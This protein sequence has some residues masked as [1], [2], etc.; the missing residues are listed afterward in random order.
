MKIVNTKVDDLSKLHLCIE[1]IKSLEKQNV[2]YIDNPINLFSVPKLDNYLFFKISVKKDEDIIWN[3]FINQDIEQDLLKDFYVNLNGLDRVYIIETNEQLLQHIEKLESSSLIALDTE[4]YPVLQNLDGVKK[5]IAKLSLIQ[6]CI[7][8][9]KESN[10]KEMFV[11]NCISDINIEFL[12]TA[13]TSSKILKMIHNASYDV[14]RIRENKAI[15]LENVWCTQIAEEFAL[16][17]AKDVRFRLA[18]LAKR[19]LGVIMDK[20]LQHSEWHQRP[21]SEEQLVYSIR[22]AKHLYDI[23]LKQI[24]KGYSRGLYTVK[25]T[26]KA[27]VTEDDINNTSL[28]DLFMHND[29]KKYITWLKEFFVSG[30][31]RNFSP[32]SFVINDVYF[33][34]NVY[35]FTQ[36]LLLL[37][38]QTVDL[39]NTQ[40]QTGFSLLDLLKGFHNFISDNDRTVYSAHCKLCATTL[41]DNDSISKETCYICRHYKSKIK[42]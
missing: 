31:A 30:N 40:L 5:T 36:D 29:N 9:N 23:Y 18:D 6:L 20:T 16:G 3:I 7:Q 19:H 34:A 2:F 17:N 12:R 22:D 25:N 21:L 27:L 4:T 41:Y 37:V 42:H 13:F 11:I 1:K 10:K 15:L 24:E 26:K 35:D 28:L 32:S 8:P 33:I 14:S 39:E 38:M